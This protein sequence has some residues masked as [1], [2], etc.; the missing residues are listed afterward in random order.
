[1]IGHVRY[2]YA[3]MPIERELN[4]EC[5]L[6]MKERLPPVL[7]DKFRQDD[8]DGS[9]LVHLSHRFDIGDERTDERTIGRFNDDIR[10]EAPDDCTGV[11]LASF[12][13]CLRSRPFSPR[14]SDL[15]LVLRVNADVDR[16]RFFA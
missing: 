8:R 3:R 9:P 10:T 15:L 12:P 11:V 16:H 4:P 14:L 13:P 6:V 2:N 7:G 5:G 1:M